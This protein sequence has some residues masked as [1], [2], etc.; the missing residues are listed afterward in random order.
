MLTEEVKEAS[1]I[2]VLAPSPGHEHS[3]V[4]KMA[5]SLPCKRLSV[6]RPV[7]LGHVVKCCLR[8]SQLGL[9]HGR[10][11]SADGRK[12]Q[13]EWDG[14][15]RVCAARD[16]GMGDRVPDD[17]PVPPSLVGQGADGKRHD[18]LK[19]LPVLQ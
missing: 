14:D 19:L 3:L 10:A 11:W 7:V 9:I 16:V 8:T 5:L 6:D 12:R 1:S 17:L 13:V 4:G 2:F 18:K 15:T